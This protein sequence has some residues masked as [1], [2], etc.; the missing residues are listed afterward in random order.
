M[1]WFFG[2]TSPYWC[3]KKGSKAFFIWPNN[4]GARARFISLNAVGVCAHSHSAPSPTTHIFILRL[5]LWRTFSF[6][7]FREYFNEVGDKGQLILRIL[8]M[9]LFEHS[10]NTPIFI[11][12]LLLQRT[13]SFRAFS[14]GA[15]C[16]STPS[17]NLN[18]NFPSP[19]LDWDGG[20]AQ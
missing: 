16:P 7:A 9:R 11:L 18:V 5:L 19:F 15:H 8:L 1:R 3:G 2:L 4:N 20:V 17:P 6:R 13:F 12:R 14:Y 10:P